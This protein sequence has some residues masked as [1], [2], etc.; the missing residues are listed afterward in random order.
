SAPRRRGRRA[1]MNLRRVRQVPASVGQ[2]SLWFL[3]GVMPCKTP[4]NTAVQFHL[5]DAHGAGELDALAPPRAFEEGARR[6]QSPRTTVAPPDSGVC[7]II[8]S[9][10]D[11][12]PDVSIVEADGRSA[13]EIAR[14]IAATPFDLEHGPLFRVRIVKEGPREHRLICVMDHIIA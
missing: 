5:R 4:Y 13:D 14:E 7:Q 8:S 9:A 6:P 2:A 10:E 12:R 3:R 11:V 1:H